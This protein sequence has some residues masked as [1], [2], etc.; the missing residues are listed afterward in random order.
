MKNLL[1]IIL[2]C[3]QA[4]PVGEAGAVFLLIAP[5]AGPVGTGEAQ[6]AKADDV[7]ASY[8][9]PAGLGYLS[10]SEL[11]VMHVNWLPNLAD[12]IYYD[13]LAYRY[14]IPNLGTIGTN[15]IYLNLGE[16]IRTDEEGNSLG[17]F[18]SNM[19]SLS[20]SFG[21][22]ITNSSSIGLGFKVIQQNLAPEGAGSEGTKG[23][24][25]NI[26]FD[27]GYL[28]KFIQMGKTGIFTEFNF[29]LSLSNIG[30][31]I[32]FQDKGQADPA[33]TNM[34]F[35]IYSTLYNNNFNKISFLLDAN[36]LLVARYP[37]MDWDGDG[38]ISGYNEKAHSD[39]WYKAIFTS[40]LDDWY[41]GGDYDYNNDFLI[42]GW[43]CDGSI[44]SEA[45]GSYKCDGSSDNFIQQEGGDYALDSDANKVYLEKGT[46]ESRKFSSEMKEMIY[47][48]G[49]EYWYSNI[50]VLRGGYIYDYEG[51]IANPTFGAGLRFG[52][53]GFDFGYT[54]G[55]Q[56]HPRSNTMFFSINIGV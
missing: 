47:N 35:G 1:L 20:T 6:V 15:L 5:G 50:F 18:S 23:S 39:S 37:A 33:P 31:K 16:Q 30:P 46:G 34:K 56:G 55:E 49:V 36:K 4:F 3:S 11:G 2:L 44:S 45:D 52:Q 54:A 32:W 21:S 51:K 22:Q 8:Y 24:S 42:G 40:W 25:T 38:I 10:G 53:Y 12:D 7:Y 27:L 28:K 9:N 48:I 13:F 17:T 26:L 41:Y 43:K 29:G 19:W 14:S